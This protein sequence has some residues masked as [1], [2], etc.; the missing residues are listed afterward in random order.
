MRWS[1]KLVAEVEPGRMTEHEIRRS[2]EAIGSR[3]RRA[4]TLLSRHS[5]QAKVMRAPR[6]VRCQSR[7]MCQRC[8]SADNGRLAV[9]V[10]CSFHNQRARGRVD[11]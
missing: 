2:N 5:P 3:P 8:Q 11:E 9:R 10:G 1:V 4:T 6:H 7:A